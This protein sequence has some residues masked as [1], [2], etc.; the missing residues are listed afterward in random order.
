MQ[1]DEASLI[2]AARAGDMRAYGSLV[3]LHQG[4]VRAFL[5]R[6]VGEAADADD[7]A[8][9]AFARGWEILH[10]YDGK[11]ALRSFICGIAYQYWKRGRRSFVRRAQRDAAYDAAAQ[12]QAEIAPNPEAKLALRRAMDA[13]PQDQ[14]A[15]LAMCIGQDFTH[16]EAAAALSLPLGT[17]KSHVTR[18]LAK[19]RDALGATP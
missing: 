7:I 1:A 18:G 3:D 8:Q 13:L 15:A 9:E 14:R 19:L 5:R 11:A 6:L 16:A 12:L 17:I 2:A 10:R 4:A